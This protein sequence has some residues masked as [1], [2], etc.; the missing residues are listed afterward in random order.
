MKGVI[1]M[2]MELYF[3]IDVVE[4]M[5]NSLTWFL[6]V[7]FAYR[8]RKKKSLVIPM[9]K[10]MV[11]VIIGLFSFSLELNFFETPFRF[12]LLPLGVWLLYWFKGNKERWER[13]RIFAW[14]GFGANFLFLLATLIS[15]PIH[16]GLYPSNKPDTYM[17][18]ISK[19]ALIHIHPSAKEQEL[20]KKALSQQLSQLE[21]DTVYSEEWHQDTYMNADLNKRRERFPYQLIGVASKWGSGLSPIIYL[22]EDGKGLLIST[23]K[24]QYYFRSKDSIFLRKG[25]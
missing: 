9:W 19:A 3:Q 24:E 25:E 11:V 16:A 13:Y 22:E 23:S 8:I 12:A 17:A 5:V 1:V 4:V 7:Y 14:L 10:I 15:I 6:I 2:H 18:N 21:Q 20:D